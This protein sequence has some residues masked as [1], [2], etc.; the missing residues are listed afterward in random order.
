MARIID[1]VLKVVIAEKDEQIAFVKPVFFIPKNTMHFRQIHSLVHHK[2]RWGQ[3][4]SLCN[5]R[6]GFAAILYPGTHVSIC[7]LKEM[8]FGI[9]QNLCTNV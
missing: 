8:T 6:G 3:T 4:I 9:K 1:L 7:S 5:D 2:M